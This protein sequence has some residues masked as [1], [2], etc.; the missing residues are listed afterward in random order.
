MLQR[1]FP[2]LRFTTKWSGT[3]VVV[4]EMLGEGANGAVYRVRTPLGRAAMKVCT[5][6]SDVAM[7][8]SLLTSL[9]QGAKAFPKPMLIDDGP[10]EAPFFYVMEW[11]PGIPLNQAIEHRDFGTVIGAFE[12]I[13]L[14]LTDLHAARYAFCDLKPE[15]VMVVHEPGGVAIRFVDVGGVTQFGRS[16]RQYTPLCDRAFFGVGTRKAEPSY[17]VSALLLGLLCAFLPGHGADLAKLDPLR[18]LRTVQQSMQDFPVPGL[19]M[20]F[21]ALLQKRIVDAHDLWQAWN[22]LPETAR[23]VSVKP[24]GRKNT[25]KR[26]VHTKRPSTSGQRVQQRGQHVSGKPRTRKTDWT[27]WVMWVSLGSAGFVCVA[28]WAVVLGWLP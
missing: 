4:E 24:R 17:D 12:A 27:E 16:V 19:P 15:N 18:R 5:S 22:G 25:A 10:A 8:W 23:R 20:L 1:P 28:A 9:G 26:V 2:G 13:I 3:P 7:E 14:A 6:S 21:E 11:I